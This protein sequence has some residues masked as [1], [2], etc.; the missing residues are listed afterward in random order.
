[1][2]RAVA[3]RVPEENTGG[4]GRAFVEAQ[5]AM[6]LFRLGRRDAALAQLARSVEVLEHVKEKPGY[7]MRALA[8]AR[9]LLARALTDTGRPDRAVPLLVAAMDW[10][11][12]LALDQ[13][14]RAGVDCELARARLLHEGDAGQLAVLRRCAPVYR[15]WGQA[16]TEV[17]QS[18]DRLLD[19]QPEPAARTANA[20]VP[21]S[22]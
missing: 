21:S 12:R 6:I 22:R 7:P 13:P 15:R 11:G 4:A 20:L 19:R 3:T 1:M 2:D 18:F 8:M 9:V 14:A 10:Y 17:A 5:R 16:E